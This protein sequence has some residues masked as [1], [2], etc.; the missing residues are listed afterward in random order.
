MVG[1]HTHTRPPARTQQDKYASPERPSVRLST[2]SSTLCGGTSVGLNIKR[3]DSKFRFHHD[4]MQWLCLG[5]HIYR[6][7]VA[8]GGIVLS[9]TPYEITYARALPRRTVRK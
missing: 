7:T 3:S 5:F 1:K 4:D 9:V 2:R 6:A 8:K